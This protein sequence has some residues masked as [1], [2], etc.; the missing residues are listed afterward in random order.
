MER[1]LYVK[2]KCFTCLGKGFGCNYCDSQGLAYI[3]ASDKTLK[4]WF[5]SLNDE[6]KDEIRNL[7]KE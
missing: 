4:E 2:N 6:R 3:E 7:L 5:F 1:K